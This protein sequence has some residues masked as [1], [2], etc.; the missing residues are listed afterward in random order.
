MDVRSEK[1]KSLIGADVDGKNNGIDWVLC[2]GCG[3]LLSLRRGSRCSMLLR[4]RKS[5]EVCYCAYDQSNNITNSITSM[6][7]PF[8]GWTF[9]MHTL[10]SLLVYPPSSSSSNVVSVLNAFFFNFFPKRNC[11]KLVKIYKEDFATHRHSR[12][13][14]VGDF[15]VIGASSCLTTSMA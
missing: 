15:L 13:A 2:G 10:Q 14:H 11:G 12:L 7:G 5:G 1:W 4:L 8:F 3:F 9:W 6:D